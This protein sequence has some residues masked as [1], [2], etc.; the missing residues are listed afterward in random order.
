VRRI[1]LCAPGDLNEICHARLR[2]RRRIRGPGGLVL[3]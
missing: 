1:P 3:S 2:T